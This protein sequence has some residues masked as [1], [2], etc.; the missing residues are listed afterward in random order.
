VRS[1]GVGVAGSHGQGVLGGDHEAVA[2]GAEEAAQDLLGL[3]LVV[4]VGGVEEGAPRLGEHAQDSAALFLVGAEAAGL[5]DAHGAQAELRDPP[6]AR[7][8]QLVAH[9][10]VLS[11][12]LSAGR[13]CCSPPDRDAEPGR[14]H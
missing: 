13:S 9:P 5:A 14:C 4:A 7:A 8:Q 1:G 12:Q 3:G 2:V 10:P 11:S 6:A